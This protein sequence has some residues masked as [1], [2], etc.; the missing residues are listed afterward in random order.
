MHW[1]SK[2]LL[3]GNGGSNARV[4]LKRIWYWLGLVKLVN[5]IDE[6]IGVHRENHTTW[7]KKLYIWSHTCMVV[8]NASLHWLASNS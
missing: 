8:S 6:E 3:T 4:K 2:V 1:D 5:F 7:H